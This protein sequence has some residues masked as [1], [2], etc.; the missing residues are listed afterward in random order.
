MTLRCPVCRDRH[1]RAV[2]PYRH[3]SALFAG[4]SRTTCDTCGMVFAS[5]MPDAIALAAYNTSYFDS[6]H[7]GVPTD[8]IAIAFHSGINRLRVVHVERFLHARGVA[9][10]SVLEV[11]AGGGYFARH[12]LARHPDSSYHAIESDTSCHPGLLA[13]GVE[14]LQDPRDA[15]QPLLDLV[16]MSHVLEHTADPSD[17]LQK[18]TARLRRGG[19]LFIEVPCRDWEFKAEDEPHLLF[20]D[21]IPMTRLLSD[22]GFAEIQLT[23]H[24]REIAKLRSPSLVA[25]VVRRVRARLLVHGVVAPFAR[26]TAGLEVLEEPLERAAVAPYE[27][28]RECS[29]PAWWLRAAAQK[30]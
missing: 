18:M 15:Q 25:R 12:W 6:A 17:F 16:V 3:T 26:I 23:Y 1:V 5:P 2:A 22:L 4:R 13:I 29:R 7:G 21:K 28:H 27:A 9:V 30:L 19:V 24:G 11:G 10:S 20:F 14:V 8:S